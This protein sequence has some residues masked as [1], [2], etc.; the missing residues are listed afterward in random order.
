MDTVLTIAQKVCEE[1]RITS[2]SALVGTTDSNYILIK[3]LIEKAVGD[4][5]DG[6]PWPELLKE[7]TFTLSTG[8][9]NYPFPA[10]F[11]RQAFE[12][13]WNRT[14]RWPLIGPLTPI[15]WQNIKSGIVTT[16]PRQRFIVKSYADSQLYIDP[17]PTASE[18]GQTI[19]FNY[20]SKNCFKPKTWVTNTVFA[21]GSWCSYNGNFY[22]TTAGGTTG[23]TPPTHTSGSVSDGAVTWTFSSS[24]YE[25]IVAD[26]D[27]PILDS[28][29]IIDEVV[30]RFKRESKF[31][32]WESLRKESQDKIEL[33]K[34]KLSS[35]AV[36]TIG[37][38]RL[39]PPMMGTWSYPF[40]N[41]GI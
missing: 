35:A 37:N 7:T 32:N 25:Y 28:R 16:M 11:D 8:V 29:T 13:I 40:A 27:S 24:P 30:W 17:T 15:E 14:Q 22:T 2:P 1:C 21:A 31:D 23:A 38:K 19:V 6:F 5:G 9:A 3:R 4:L 33:A 36:L 20:F 41:Y 12:T 26:T 10:D 39:D 18:N 34:S